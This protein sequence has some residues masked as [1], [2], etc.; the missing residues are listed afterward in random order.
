MSRLTRLIN[1]WPVM[2][3]GGL[4]ALLLGRVMGWIVHSA[5]GA[6]ASETAALFVTWATLGVTFVFCV[7]VALFPRRPDS[8]LE[9][10][11]RGG[12]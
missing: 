1:L 3:L 5:S 9:R 12:S 11:I 8:Y 6:S 7:W 4:F 2:L 10:T